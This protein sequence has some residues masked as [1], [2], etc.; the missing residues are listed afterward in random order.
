MYLFFFSNILF[1]LISKIAV[2]KLNKIHFLVAINHVFSKLMKWIHVID[3][4]NN[5]FQGS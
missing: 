5:S 2:K 3:H 1:F 4:A